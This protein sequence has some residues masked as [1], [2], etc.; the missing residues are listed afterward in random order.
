MRRT[1]ALLGS[2]LATVLTL[3]L[4]SAQPARAATPLAAPTEPFSNNA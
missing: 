1:L 3:S 2:T 4:L